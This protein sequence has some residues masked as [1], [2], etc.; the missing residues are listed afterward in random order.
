[1]Q[2]RTK[3]A[4]ILVIFFSVIGVNGCGQKQPLYLPE[5]PTEN[6]P[7]ATTNQPAAANQD[8]EQN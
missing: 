7:P 6:K 4:L 1:M 5:A 8:Q 2:H 3:N